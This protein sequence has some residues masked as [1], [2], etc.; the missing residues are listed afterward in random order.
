MDGR[1]KWADYEIGG[2]SSDIRYHEFFPGVEGNL[3]VDFKPL[4]N[5]DEKYGKLYDLLNKQ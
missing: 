1:Y 4:A 3:W 5:L 2:F